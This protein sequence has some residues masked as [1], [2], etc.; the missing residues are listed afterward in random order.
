MN[1]LYLAPRFEVSAGRLHGCTPWFARLLWLFSYCRCLTVN[2]RLS[3]L[4]IST[5]RLWL[6]R[7]IRRIRF[8]EV[9]RIVYRAQAL[10]S[11]NPLR[12]LSFDDSDA[13]DS[14]FFLISLALKDS[15]E[16]LPLFTVWEQQPHADD[17]LDDLAGNHAVPEIGDEAAGT[18]VRLL[19]E[20]IGVPV[21]QH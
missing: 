15:A 14:A 9:S 2:R 8:D 3:R 10:P 19:H 13:S 6:W 18:V 12:Y 16:E 21:A 11:L 7:T 17:W 4:T 20:Y 1:H 5:R